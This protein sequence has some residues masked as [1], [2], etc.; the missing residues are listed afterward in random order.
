MSSPAARSRAT[1][2]ATAATASQCM[3]QTEPAY[4]TRYRPPR[5][6]ASADGA[7]PD[8]DTG[9]CTT[10]AGRSMP[11]LDRIDSR[12][13]LEMTSQ[14]RDARSSARPRR[15]VLNA[16][17]TLSRCESQS[18]MR[19]VTTGTFG[20]IAAHRSASAMPTGCVGAASTS[21]GAKA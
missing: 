1:L 8:N 2:A 3:G 4:A 18:S 20:L 9:L 21:C 19:Y 5:G 6:A 10:W 11:V 7:P 15:G 13:Y 16:S 14:P 12:R 17:C